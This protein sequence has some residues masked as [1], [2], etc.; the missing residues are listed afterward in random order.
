MI[1][2]KKMSDWISV[3]ERLPK[4]GTLV[5]AFVLEDKYSELSGAVT[6]FYEYADGFACWS[7]FDPNRDDY[8]IEI[9]RDEVTHW[10]PLPEPPKSEH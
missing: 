1:M 3:T 4:D 9:R 10:M 2:R 8:D 6:L 5:T 7:I